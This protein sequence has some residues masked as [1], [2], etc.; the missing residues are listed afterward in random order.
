MKRKN[1]AY[2]VDVIWS[3]NT[4]SGTRSYKEYSRDHLLRAAGKQDIAGSSD[5]AF[6]GDP[7]RWNPEDLLVGSLSACHKLWYLG[8]CAASGVNVLAY[9]DHAEGIM[10]EEAGGAGQF[11]QVTLNP[12]ITISADSDPDVAIAL[13]HKAHEMCF[14]ARS[15]NFPVEHN[16]TI[17]KSGD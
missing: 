15:V 3:G 10:E 6:R 4:G 13:H 12:A 8:L 16:P 9:E 2:H 11:I 14:I 7:S 17:V 1:H 5:P